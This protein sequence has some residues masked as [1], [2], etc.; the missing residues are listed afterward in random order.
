MDFAEF[1]GP[2]SGLYF[3]Q[4]VPGLG[5]IWGVFY[6]CVQVWDTAAELH[7][8]QFPPFPHRVKNLGIL[9]PGIGLGLMITRLLG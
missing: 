7:S 6:S 2:P 8:F 3:A 9:G 1:L 5:R 4:R